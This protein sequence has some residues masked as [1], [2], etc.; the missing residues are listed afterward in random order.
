ML[1]S[2]LTLFISPALR[3]VLYTGPVLAF[4]FGGV[5]SMIPSLVS[6]LYGM[7]HFGQNWVRTHTD[8]C[9]YFVLMGGVLSLCALCALCVGLCVRVLRAC[10]L[11]FCVRLC[12]CLCTPSSLRAGWCLR[13]ARA[14]SR[15]T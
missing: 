14:G 15:S 8:A 3:T 5:F 2:H 9:A 4:G 10:T 12:G 11:L 7:P 13:V 1:C 6:L